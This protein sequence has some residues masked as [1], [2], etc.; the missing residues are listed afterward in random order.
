MSQIRENI[1]NKALVCIDEVYPDAAENASFFPVDKFL[2]E[3]GAAIVRVVPLHVLGFGEDFS[4]MDFTPNSDGSGRICLPDDF[5][6]L[7]NFKMQGWQRPV[8]APIYDTDVK[9][10]QQFNMALRGGEAKPV[11]AIV[12]GGKFLEYFSSSDGINAKVETARYF[13]YSVI[14]RHYPTILLDITAWKLAELVLSSISDINAA[15]QCQNKV[16]EL[17]QIL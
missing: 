13:G 8:V 14:D 12:N 15:Q 9:Y 3:A 16:N 17:L 4:N 7:I 6:R 2:D 11:V 5:V 1:K 10:R